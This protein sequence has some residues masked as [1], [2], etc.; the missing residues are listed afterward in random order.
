ML[1]SSVRELITIDGMQFSFMS[2]RGT[3][4]ALFIDRRIQEEHKNKERKSYMCFADI[5]MAFDRVPKKV[6]KCK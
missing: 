2:S 5:E 4:C 6:K 1:E 3:T